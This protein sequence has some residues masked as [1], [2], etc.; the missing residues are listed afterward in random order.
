[1]S[2]RS[3]DSDDIFTN[4]HTHELVYDCFTNRHN[5]VDKI[6]VLDQILSF[7]DYIILDAFS[8]ELQL[9]VCKATFKV[10]F[11]NLEQCRESFKIILILTSLNTRDELINTGKVVVFSKVKCPLL[12]LLQCRIYSYP[13]HANALF[14]GQILD[15]IRSSSLTKEILLDWFL[16]IILSLQAVYGC[17]VTY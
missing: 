10:W 14:I 15:S 17:G 13:I 11:F 9:N 5:Q 1:V 16:V 2:E 12:P 4:I 8:Y 3:Y 7:K 6:V